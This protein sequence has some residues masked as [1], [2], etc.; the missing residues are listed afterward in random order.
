MSSS[1]ISTYL[2]PFRAQ[3][4]APGRCPS[5]PESHKT[6]PKL[7]EQSRVWRGSWLLFD[8]TG[9]GDGVNISCGTRIDPPFAKRLDWKHTLY[10]SL[11]P[12]FKQPQGAVDPGLLVICR[13]ASIAENCYEFGF[14]GDA[15]RVSHFTPFISPIIFEAT[16][17]FRG[18]TLSVP[19]AMLLRAEKALSTGCSREEELPSSFERTTPAS[20]WYSLFSHA[21]TLAGRCTCTTSIT[22]AFPAL[23]N[24]REAHYPIIFS[25]CS[26][27]DLKNHPRGLSQIL[28]STQLPLRKP[29]MDSR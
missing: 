21:N 24:D 11:A 27:P 15:P 10:S 2:H 20:T 13:A 16:A 1:R 17:C 18:G 7:L 25:Y 19:L 9:A 14:H 22:N 3:P 29:S 4:A 8:T 28:V 6:L 12:A 5:H 26:W 23:G